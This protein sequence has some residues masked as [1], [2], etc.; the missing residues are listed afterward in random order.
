IADKTWNMLPDKGKAIM[1]A[2]RE[3]ASFVCDAVNLEGIPFTLP[4]IQTLLDG[5]TV[6]GHRLEEQ[7]IAV[8]QGNAWKHLFASLQSGSF[9][10]SAEYACKL[11][12]I[13]AKEEALTWGAFRNGGV[14]IAGT[15]WEPPSYDTLPSRFADMV[16][17]AGRMDD[18]YGRAIFVFLEMARNQFFYDVNKRLGRLM[19]NGILLDAGYPAINLP[20]R[21]Q[22]EFNQLMLEFYPSGDPA[23]MNRFMRS[24]LDERIIGIMQETR[25]TKK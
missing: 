23:P 5:I 8:N 14:T 11:H 25:Q 13:A 12:A 7:Q 2:Q 15:S 17:A 6:G 9:I 22:L 3:V 20:A 16:A 24:C 1:L 4:E 19:M 18:I 21:R 10:L